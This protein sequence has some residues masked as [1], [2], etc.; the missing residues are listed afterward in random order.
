MLIILSNKI[1]RYLKFNS[2]KNSV[3]LRDFWFGTEECV[4]LRGLRCET[5]G[6]L[7]L[8]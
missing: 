3:E 5:E 8:N 4:E 2:D 7:V 6:V 1:F